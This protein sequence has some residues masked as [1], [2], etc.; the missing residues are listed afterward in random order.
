MIFVPNKKVACTPLGNYRNVK[1]KG[2]GFKTAEQKHSLLELT[3]VH[4]NERYEPG[5][6]VWIRGD[7]MTLTCTKEEF[8]G[9]Q[10]E[11]FIL[12]PEEFIQLQ[13]KQSLPNYLVSTRVT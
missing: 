6:K 10:G 9:P 11:V 8:T 5:D 2:D 3:V 1:L 13:S 7:A 12:I 4:G